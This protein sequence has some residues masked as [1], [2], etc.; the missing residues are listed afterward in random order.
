ML[1]H[2]FLESQRWIRK[3]DIQWVIGISALTLLVE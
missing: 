3:S 2:P 1:E